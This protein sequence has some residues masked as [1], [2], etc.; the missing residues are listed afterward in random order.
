MAEGLNRAILVGNLGVDPELKFTQGGQAVLRI[1]LATTESFLN[2]TGERQE[3]TD[4]HTV[5]VWG[6]RAE[7]LNKILSKGRT[8]W[9]EGR[10]QTR[11]WEDKD[12]GKR[13]STE[14]NANNIGLVGGSGG[15]GERSAGGRMG[16]GGGTGGGHE[17]GYDGGPD[18]D[19]GGDDDIPF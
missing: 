17:G 12:G 14:I 6:K 19:S 16:G 8:I 5:V 15:G 3:R 11:S 2:R 1:R 10:I 4:W 7:A 9:V 18:Y 13:Y